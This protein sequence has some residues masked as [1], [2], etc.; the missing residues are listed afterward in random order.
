MAFYLSPAFAVAFG[1]V[2]LRDEISV[3][4]VRGLGAIVVGSVL[5]AHRSEPAPP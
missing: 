1:V 3:A 5:A 4:A 2:F